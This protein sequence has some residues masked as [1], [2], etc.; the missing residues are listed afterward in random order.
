LF[1]CLFVC[2][3]LTKTLGGILFNTFDHVLS[4]PQLLPDHLL[5][6]A[7]AEWQLQ[8]GSWLLLATTHT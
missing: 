2:L 3:F 4:L 8:N 6:E 5:W 7:V 1:V